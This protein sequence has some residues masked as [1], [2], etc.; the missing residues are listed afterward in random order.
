L[1]LRLDAVRPTSP[2]RADIWQAT[3]SPY[4]YVTTPWERL[5]AEGEV[6]SVYEK[7][8]LVAKRIR[9]THNN[10]YPRLCTYVYRYNTIIFKFFISFLRVILF[11]H[12]MRYV[13]SIL[14]CVKQVCGVCG[15]GLERQIIIVYWAQPKQTSVLC[16]ILHIIHI[17]QPRGFMSSVCP[18]KNCS[19]LENSRFSSRWPRARSL[20]AKRLRV[21]I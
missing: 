20:T 16:T 4:S 9:I 1:S 2:P 7:S 13:T 15:I 5:W 19:Q 6:C 8:Q 17:I 14:L 11:C 21:M 3:F 12:V 18:T 10:I